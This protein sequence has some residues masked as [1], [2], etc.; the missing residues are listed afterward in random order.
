[1][2]KDEWKKTMM[3]LAFTVDAASVV[4][5]DTQAS[6]QEAMTITEC[7]MSKADMLKD[8]WELVW[9]PRVY[10]FPLVSHGESNNTMLVA[11]STDEA[12]TYAVAIAGTNGSSWSDWL[13]ED[14]WVTRQNRWPYGSPPASPVAKVSTATWI[15][16]KCLQ[17]M[18]PYQ[19]IPGAGKD[20]AG[21][22]KDE[23]AKVQGDIT[24]YVTG[25]SLGGALAP[26]TALW[27]HDT[28]KGGPWW[29]GQIAWD[30]D[31]R[32]TVKT[33]PFAGATP[34]NGA[35]KSY[36]DSQFE[37]DR[38]VVVNN[39]LDM[40]PHAWNYETLMEIPDLYPQPWQCP[41]TFGKLIDGVAAGLKP[42]DYQFVGQGDQ[43]Q[44]ITG[45]IADIPNPP[46]S[47][48]GRFFAQA[49][50]QH[51]NVYFEKLGLEQ[52]GEVMGECTPK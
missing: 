41:A 18:V 9:G 26:A 2:T 15:G 6:N 7:V 38:M 22:L 33:Y 20:L 11:K 43:V 10:D 12:N 32:A 17:G 35:F 14:F 28:R 45:D 3:S 51:I 34:G 25:H 37:G 49:L 24:V 19:G 21:F 30:P 52:L 1:M 36:I 16:L 5:G 47:Q 48:I 44:P 39:T 40:V 8:K 42:L 46:K 4:K 50:Y 23:A 29:T 27:L 31:E 13:F